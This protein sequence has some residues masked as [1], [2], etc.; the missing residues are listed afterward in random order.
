MTTLVSYNILAGGYSIHDNDAPRTQ[1]LLSII[2]SANPDIVGLAE[3]TQS[4]VKHKPVVIEELAEALDMRLIRGKSPRRAD[5][6]HTAL[7]TRLPVVDTQ[8]HS[9]PNLHRALLEVRVQETNGRQFTVFVAHLSA[10]FDRGRAGGAIRRREIG[11]IL[12][13]LAP[14]RAQG[15]PHVIMGDFNSLAPGD[16]FHA[17][18]L[19]SYILDIEREKSDPHLDDGHPQLRVIVPPA[20]RF[21]KPILRII[22]RSQLISTLFNSA[23]S[24]YAP[25]DCIQLLRDANYVDCY[26]RIHP[27][28]LGFT[29]PAAAPAGRIDFIFA[30]P[31]MADRLETCYVLKDGEGVQG[32]EA[33]DHLAVA[34]EFGSH[35]QPTERA[36]TF[37]QVA[38]N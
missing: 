20:L 38:V 1:Q 32:S 3:A 31:Q 30:S 22:P 18:S 9:H 19:V 16:R 21:V 7:L 26:R 10:A 36:E 12:R 17:S 15:V 2:R 33:S 29:C 8:L 27:Q 37:A 11:E 28:A 5:D 25:R 35:T 4:V 13:I 23:A 34:A 14:A 24:L 6:Y